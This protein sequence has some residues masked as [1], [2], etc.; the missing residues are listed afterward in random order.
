MFIDL[1]TDKYV[2]EPLFFF[3]IFSSSNINLWSMEHDIRAN[4]G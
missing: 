1:T 4:I 3:N 2:M